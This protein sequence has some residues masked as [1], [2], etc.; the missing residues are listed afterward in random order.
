MF[1]INIENT[2]LQYIDD[3]QHS[4]SYSSTTNS[5]YSFATWEISESQPD[6]TAI[7]STGKWSNWY[8]VWLPS[9]ATARRW[10]E[11]CFCSCRRQPVW[12]ICGWCWQCQRP[13]WCICSWC[14][15]PTVLWLMP[16]FSLSSCVL[17]PNSWRH[18]VCTWMISRT[19]PPPHHSE[20]ASPG[21]TVISLHKKQKSMT[22]HVPFL[23]KSPEQKESSMYLLIKMIISSV[24]CLKIYKHGL[25]Q[26]VVHVGQV[27]CLPIGQVDWVAVYSLII[28]KVNIRITWIL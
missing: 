27:I 3:Q 21:M 12:Y 15:C 2:Y 22:H 16:T 1:N 9:A 6:C 11:G 23:K 18:S 19:L 17:F 26:I 13:A 28:D 20:A 14:R 8:P 5:S 24:S 4:C 7:G 10:V 25:V